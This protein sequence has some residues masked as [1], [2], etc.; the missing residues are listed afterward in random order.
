MPA[1][2]FD[3]SLVVVIVDF[4]P[5][6]E[7]HLKCCASDF[8]WERKKLVG[9]NKLCDI[10]S[11]LPFFFLVPSDWLPS[12]YQFQNHMVHQLNRTYE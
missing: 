5:V 11:L 2:D 7:Y 3:T 1:T 12:C 8:H 4:D 6:F 10:V 9:S